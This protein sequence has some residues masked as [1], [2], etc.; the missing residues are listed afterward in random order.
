MMDADADPL[1]RMPRTR[2]MGWSG[3][4]FGMHLR[5]IGAKRFIASMWIG[6]RG[7]WW[8]WFESEFAR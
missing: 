2:R 3:Q 7:R 4:Y 8:I 5:M 1:V 6:S